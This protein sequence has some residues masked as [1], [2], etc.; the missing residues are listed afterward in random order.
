GA[1]FDSSRGRGTEFTFRVGAR[2][3][4]RGWDTGVAT[5]KVGERAYLL[6]APDYGYGAAGAADVIPPG[7]WLLFDVELCRIQ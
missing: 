1:P 3:V 4:I 2:H 7:S 5:M 6:L